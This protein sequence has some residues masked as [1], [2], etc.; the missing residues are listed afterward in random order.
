MRSIAKLFLCVLLI[1]SLFAQEK[2]K[3]HSLTV[4][5]GGPALI[6]SFEYQYAFIKKNN[7]SLSI[8]VAF[9]S[10]GFWFTG[11]SGLQY[12]YGD[13]KKLLLG[14]Y[15]LANYINDFDNFYPDKE[16]FYSTSLMPKLGYEQKTQIFFTDTYLHIYF[17]PIINIST[18]RILPW[19]GLGMTQY[20]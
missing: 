6:V 3:R 9:G 7:H 15:V 16:W 10:G 8:P 14:I 19:F 4:D 13:E 17:S 1:T 12:S 2:V 18:S 5:I 11:G 20:F